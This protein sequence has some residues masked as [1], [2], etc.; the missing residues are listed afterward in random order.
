M[1]PAETYRANAAA[2]REAAAKTTLANRREMHER[3]ASTWEAMAEAIED[4]AARA[5]V[6]AAAKAER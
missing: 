1:T 2:Q 5:V 3:S 4:T 6:N